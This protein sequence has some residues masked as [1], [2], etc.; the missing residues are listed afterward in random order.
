LKRFLLI[1]VVAAWVA[2]CA[3]GPGLASPNCADGVCVK[4]EV[5]EPVALGQPAIFTITVT[6]DQDRPDLGVTLY[7][8]D[9]DVVVEGPQGWEATA[10]EGKVWK[11]SAGWSFAAKANVPVVFKRVLRFPAREA[12]FSAI[13]ALHV[14]PRSYIAF[15]Q[16]GFQLAAAGARVY[17]AGT[18]LPTDAS[19]YR[20]TVAPAVNAQGTVI[21][22]P[23]PHAPTVPSIP[24][25]ALTPTPRPYP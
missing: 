20:A 10:R 11:A 21:P 9:A 13:V 14:G 12:Y 16:I 2:A 24:T 3:A 25:R 22:T 17:R 5:A 6:S 4:L 18:P 15:D 23:S 8:D 1:A 19:M 7:S